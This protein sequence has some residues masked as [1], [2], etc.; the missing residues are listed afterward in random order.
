MVGTQQIGGDKIFADSSFII[1]AI[2]LSC[3]NK[4]K[5]YSRN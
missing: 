1:V 2:V 3:Y 4:Y 5:K